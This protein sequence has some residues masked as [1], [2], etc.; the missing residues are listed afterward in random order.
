MTTLNLPTYTP[1]MSPMGDAIFDPIRNKN[2][3]LTPEEW[4]RQHVLNYLVHHLGYPAGR[5]A[6]ERELK[7]NQLKRRFDILIYD[8]QLKPYL[9]VEC[10]AHDIAIT[11]QTF[12][13]IAMYNKVVQAKVL[14]VTN[15]IT[16]YCS[17]FNPIKKNYEFT[18]EIPAYTIY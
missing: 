5:I 14:V 6:V 18:N 7:Y 17:I 10:K 13:Q 4:V 9:I 15:G 8:A 16:H 3:V 12:N 2:F 1:I 11:Q